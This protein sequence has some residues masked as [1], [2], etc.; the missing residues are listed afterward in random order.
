M[1]SLLLEIKGIRPRNDIFEGDL[2]RI[3]DWLRLVDF[4][5]RRYRH[6][7]G[8]INCLGMFNPKD[9][10]HLTSDE[11][12][13]EIKANFV[14]VVLGVQA[15]LPVMREQRGGVIVSIGSL[16]GIV[17]MPGSPIYCATKHAVRG[18]S[19]SM[20]EE[21]RGSGVSLGLLS[22]G[23]VSTKMLDLEASSDRSIIT[24]VNKPLHPDKVAQAVV[25]LLLRPRPELIVPPV[26]GALC[27]LSDL[28]PHLFTLCYR[29]LRG[30]G[31]LRLHAY[32]QQIHN[33]PTHTHW[34]NELEHA[35]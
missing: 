29:M 35:Y 19:L 21:Y 27:L 11:I 30:V 24:F 13:S 14:S 8:L 33:T 26:T 31:E 1:E 20:N 16:G 18:F 22:L 25:S 6:L 12:D 15:A 32:Q 28:S 4:V 10:V 23:P 17:P 2:C 9:L 5:Q 3:H 7:D 34:E